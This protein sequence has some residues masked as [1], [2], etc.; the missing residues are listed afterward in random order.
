MRNLYVIPCY[1]HQSFIF[2]SICSLL[3][4]M[5]ERY[6][7][8]LVLNDEPGINLQYLELLDKEHRVH[9]VIVKQDNIHRGQTYR[10]NEAIEFAIRNDFRWLGCQAADDYALPIKC[11]LYKTDWDNVAVFYSD[12]LQQEISGNIITYIKSKPFDLEALKINNFIAAGTTLINIRFLQDN[13]IRFNSDLKYG[14]DWYLYNQIAKAGGTSVFH[15]EPAPSLL[16]RNYTSRIGIREN[17]VL[18]GQKREE[19]KQA[20]VKLWQS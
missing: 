18:W 11:R 4:Q 10:W 1:Q 14:E 2:D 3:P 9:R 15:Y 20:I 16:Y 19:L 7:Q 5:H 8:I 13:K 6:D 17:P 12:F